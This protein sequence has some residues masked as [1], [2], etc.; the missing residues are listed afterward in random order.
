MSGSDEA[1]ASIVEA[2]ILPNEAIA[3]KALPNC[4]ICFIE[5]NEMKASISVFYEKL[6]EADNSSILAIPDDA[7]YYVK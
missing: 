3:K 6:F 4:N 7:F 2:G 1:I 5:G